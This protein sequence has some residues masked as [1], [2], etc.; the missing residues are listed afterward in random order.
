MA[1]LLRS[2]YIID[3][4]DIIT[5]LIVIPV[6]LDTLAWLGKDSTGI[7]RRLILETRVAY[8]VRRGQV[9]C[10]SLQRLLHTQSVIRTR[11]SQSPRPTLIK[12]PSGWARRKGGCVFIFGSSSAVLAHLVNFGTG[13]L[14]IGGSC[15]GFGFA[16]RGDRASLL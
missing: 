4:K 3:V 15:G 7:P 11:K 13:P 12:P 10:Q 6:I 5:V 9:R 2:Q 14:P 1:R 8:P 16:V